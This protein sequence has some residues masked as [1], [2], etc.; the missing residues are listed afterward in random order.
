MDEKDE[1]RRHLGLPVEIELENPQWEKFKVSMSPLLGEDLMDMLAVG[2]NFGEDVE[3]NRV[4]MTKENIKELTRLIAKSLESVPEEY[5]GN[6]A[7]KYFLD[8]FPELFNIN[9]KAVATVSPREALA[10]GEAMRKK[11][12]ELRKNDGKSPK[13]T[14]KG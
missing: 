14:R 9:F 8:L 6:I 1:W 10:K 4:A 5:K 7:S 2:R 3:K 12:E 11:L 13:D